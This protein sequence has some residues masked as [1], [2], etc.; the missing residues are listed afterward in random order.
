MNPNDSIENIVNMY[1]KH[2]SILKIK[3]HVT[4]EDTFS[5]KHI[6]SHELKNEIKALDPKKL[7]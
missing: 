3:D 2:P 4:R 6:T 5:F 1:S 7:L